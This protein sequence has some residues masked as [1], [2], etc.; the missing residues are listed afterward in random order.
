MNFMEQSEKFEVNL[1]SLSFF[2]LLSIFFVM[3]PTITEPV[4]SLTFM[5]AN[6]AYYSQSLG[7]LQVTPT[8][9]LCSLRSEHY[10]R[11]IFAQ[12]LCNIVHYFDFVLNSYSIHSFWAAHSLIS[13]ANSYLLGQLLGGP[14]VAVVL[15][16]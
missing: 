12:V 9:L 2:P 5:V 4:C 3:A 10:N 1:C 11:R 8:L 15:T 6:L 7:L 14:R 16:I 13:P